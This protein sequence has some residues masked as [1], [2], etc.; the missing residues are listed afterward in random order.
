LIPYSSVGYKIKYDA[1]NDTENSSFN[2]TGGLNKAF[3]GVGYQINR[4][5]SVGA[6]ANYNLKK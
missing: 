3:L 1:E 4:N 5:L 6:D 2:G